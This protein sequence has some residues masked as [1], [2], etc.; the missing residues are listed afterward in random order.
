LFVSPN[1]VAELREK[2][3]GGAGF[4][5]CT[6]SSVTDVEKVVS[7]NTLVLINKRITLFYVLFCFSAKKSLF[8]RDPSPPTCT[9][10]KSA[11]KKHFI[12]KKI[13]E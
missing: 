3:T 2:T 9:R 5:I 10:N 13:K 6:Q 4:V 1:T 12:S 8:A 11:F 7:K